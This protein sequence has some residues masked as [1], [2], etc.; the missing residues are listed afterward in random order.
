MEKSKGEEKDKR[1]SCERRSSGVKEE[2][3]HRFPQLYLEEIDARKGGGGDRIWLGVFS[4]EEVSGRTVDKDGDQCQK[5]KEKE[6]VIN[7]EYSMQEDLVDVNKRVMRTEGL[8]ET[9]AARKRVSKLNLED[10][11]QDENI[12]G[13]GVNTGSV[14]GLEA[15]S[16][17]K[18]NQLHGLFDEKGEWKSLD[19]DMEVII[20][21]YFSSLF[22]SSR[23]FRGQLEAVL[24]FVEAR[25]PRTM[26]D[27][28]DV[29]FIVEE[30][31][32]DLF[33]D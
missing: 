17:K 33:S 13:L 28:L 9:I 19:G 30:V 2:I 12:M 8:H 20:G 27:S 10:G 32:S 1:F 7:T 18:Q 4:S 22:T 31:R 25:L 15:S 29:L 23:P 5:I 14:V 26:R 16:R 24:N 3:E 11:G 21:H 6:V